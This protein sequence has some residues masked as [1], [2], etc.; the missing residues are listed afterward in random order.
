MMD[1]NTVSSKIVNIDMMLSSLHSSTGDRYK[2]K[3]YQALSYYAMTAYH[4]RSH[5]TIGQHGGFNTK[6]NY[7]V[8]IFFDKKPSYILCRY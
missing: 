3:E 1:W 6:L 4:H 2:M 7:Q 5:S 8:F